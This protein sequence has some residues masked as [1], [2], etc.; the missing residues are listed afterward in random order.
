MH[1]LPVKQ[2]R[3]T[4]IEYIPGYGKTGRLN[5]YRCRCDCGNERLVDVGDFNK[6]RSKSCGCYKRERMRGLTLTHD[7][8]RKPEYS[9]WHAMKDRCHNPRGKVF[10][11]YG[12]RG[13]T[14]CERWRESFAAF[15]ADMGPR[16]TPN[17]SVDRR[18]NARGYEPNNCSWQVSHVQS[19]NRR[20][21]R[22]L[23]AFGKRQCVT[24][25]SIEYGIGTQCLFARLRKG[26]PIE[27]A[28]TI[29]LNHY[30]ALQSAK[31]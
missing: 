29:P 6:G 3:L 15:L 8:C 13:I 10:Q 19:R 20:S 24:D 23:T 25:W 2:H 11:Y 28:L 31:R 27:E 12:A 21:T 7:G 5:Q 14:V 30:A 26:I 22:M 16:P 9:V 4:P 1:T 18:D 17:H